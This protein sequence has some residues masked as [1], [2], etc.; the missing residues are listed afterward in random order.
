MAAKAGQLK[1]QVFARRPEGIKMALI[2]LMVH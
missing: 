1:V 2:D